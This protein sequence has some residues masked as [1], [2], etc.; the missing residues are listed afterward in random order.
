MKISVSLTDEDVEALDLY[1]KAAGLPS[2]S[3]AVHHAI[4]LLADP[5]L[6]SAYQQAWNEWDAESDAA[7]SEPSVGD[8]LSDA[9]R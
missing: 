5:D 4:Q 9:S 1:A 7:A 2:R 6:E 3:S 8:G